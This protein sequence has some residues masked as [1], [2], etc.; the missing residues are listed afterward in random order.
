MRAS[1][2]RGTDARMNAPA[3]DGG[4]KKKILIGVGVGCLLLVMLCCVCPVGGFV[5][6]NAKAK[7]EVEDAVETWLS[8]VRAGDYD[9]AYA[10]MD[11]W[12]HSRKSREEFAMDLERCASVRTHTTATIDEISIDHPLDDFVI[13]RVSISG[14][15]AAGSEMLSIGLENDSDGWKIGTF[16]NMSDYLCSL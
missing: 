5:G 6:G 4:R 14:G 2:G 1:R 3:D 13:V 8:S 11:S 15:G 12:Y 10:G 16:S 7:G 9:A